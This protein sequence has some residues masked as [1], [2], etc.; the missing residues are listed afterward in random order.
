[1]PFEKFEKFYWIR[2]FDIVLNLS[3]VCISLLNIATKKELS[4]F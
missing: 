2:K 4:E 3:N 1:M